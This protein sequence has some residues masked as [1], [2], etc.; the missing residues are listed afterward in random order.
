VLTGGSRGNLRMRMDLK[1]NL[2]S[3][4]AYSIV[5]VLSLRRIGEGLLERHAHQRRI[6]NS[7]IPLMN[8]GIAD[9]R[10]MLTIEPDVDSEK[11]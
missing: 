4:S 6:R 11:R 2:G 3:R 1:W 10:R 5:Q 9:T 8:N 7:T